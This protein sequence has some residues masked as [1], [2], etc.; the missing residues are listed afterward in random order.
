MARADQDVEVQGF[1]YERGALFG[2]TKEP[3]L[4]EDQNNGEAHA[5]DGQ[6][7]AHFA[8]DQIEPG[9]GDSHRPLIRYFPFFGNRTSTCR[10][11]QRGRLT[12]AF[13]VKLDA[14]LNH[15]AD[16]PGQTDRRSSTQGR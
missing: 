15:G 7:G 1:E 3:Q 5:R 16:R 11:G 4:H 9:Q 13:V 10:L 12:A 2:R 8:M 14:D 6:G